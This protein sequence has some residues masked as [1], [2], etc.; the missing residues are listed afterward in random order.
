MWQTDTVLQIWDHL[1]QPC[2]ESPQALQL[3]FPKT[4]WPSFQWILSLSPVTINPLHL[5]TGL[6]IPHLSW[7]FAPLCLISLI[8]PWQ[9]F[10]PLELSQ[11][12]DPAGLEPLLVTVHEVCGAGVEEGKFRGE[13]G[14]N[15]QIPKLDWNPQWSQLYYRIRGA[16]V[17]TVSRFYL[18]SVNHMTSMIPLLWGMA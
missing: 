6:R 2:E 13:N 10:I 3:L 16:E 11:R 9:I 17:N 15:N 12:L 8:W 5:Q 18:I 7:V 1:S 4:I 14:G